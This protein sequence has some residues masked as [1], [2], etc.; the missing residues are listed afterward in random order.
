MAVADGDSDAITDYLSF[1]S[2][3]LVRLII[4]LLDDGPG[5]RRSVHS[6]CGVAP[7][8]RP[9]TALVVTDGAGGDG[10]ERRPNIR[11]SI[12]FCSRTS[13]TSAPEHFVALARRQRRP[14]GGRD[15]RDAVL[16]MQRGAGRFLSI[17]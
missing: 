17:I 14:D 4:R 16:C 15:G 11:H 12:M 10:R 9:A 13:F 5:R 3:P 2:T 7:P 8:L 1:L 6:I